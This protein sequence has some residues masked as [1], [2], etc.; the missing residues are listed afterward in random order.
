M[1]KIEKA[2]QWLEKGVKRKMLS[3]S[4]HMKAADHHH[5]QMMMH[6]EGGNKRMAKYHEEV[7]NHHISMFHKMAKKEGSKMPKKRE[8]R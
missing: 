3:A 5:D 4:D 7:A 6:H 1:N 8:M 2:K